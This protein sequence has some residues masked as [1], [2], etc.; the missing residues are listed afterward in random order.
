MQSSPLQTLV[1]RHICTCARRNATLRPLSRTFITSAARSGNAPNP[2][3]VG[4]A[5][6]LKRKYRP[7]DEDHD[8][9]KVEY[10]QIKNKNKRATAGIIVT[11]IAMFGTVYFW[12]GETKLV[13]NDAPAPNVPGIV[14]DT[15]VAVDTVETGTSSVPTFPKMITLPEGNEGSDAMPIQGDQ[16]YQL[17]GLGIRT[18]SFL[19]IQVYVVGMYIAVPDIATLQERLIRTQDSV[20]TTLV[21]GEKN[22]LREALL[23]AGKSEDIWNE[24]L[25]DG[26]IRSV[27]RIAPT[28]NTDFSHLKDGF[29]RQL[30]AKTQH[31]SANKND[32]SFGDEAFGQS[33][34]QFKALFSAAPR[35]QLPK[36]EVLLLSR[37]AKGRLQAYYEDPKGNRTKFG[38]IGD[39]RIS[40]LVWLQYLSGKTPSSEGA[41]KSVVDGVME[42]VER[43]VG[44][45]AT[46][47]I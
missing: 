47:V 21:P 4:S 39:E 14:P 38:N 29:L 43:P 41:R 24:I 16:E 45:V 9:S 1:T 23:D 12:P 15:S 42:Y 31:F 10:A 20:A 6:D 7:K 46:Q 28:R 2:A 26:K 11:T 34:D 25:K 35:K 5:E 17:V 32:Q 8:P 13:K 19:G 44:T 33:V 3:F 30:T 27:F 37:D 22:K 36:G 18:V 40:R